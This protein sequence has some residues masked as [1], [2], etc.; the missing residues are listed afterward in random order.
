MLCLD[1]QARLLLLRFQDPFD[2]R[3]FWEVPGGGIESGETPVQA[4][5]REL[6]EEAGLPPTSITDRPVMLWRSFR[7]N[8]HDHHQP[9][10]FFLAHV[11]AAEVNFDHIPADEARILKGHRWLTRAE[12][13][14]SVDLIVPENA[15]EV[16]A[17]LGA[18]PPWAADRR[19]PREL[20]TERMVLRR[21]RPD[22]APP[23]AEIYAQP[24]FLAHM[25]ALDL[26]GTRS[27]I[28]QFVRRWKDDGFCQWAAVDLATGR[29]IGRA[30]LIRH[31]DWPLSEDPV[32]VGW[33]LH[34]D[35]WGRGLATEGGRAAIDCWRDL[36]DDDQLISITRP[37]NARSRAV[38]E[39]LGM[40]LRGAT[41][42]RDQDVVWYAIDR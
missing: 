39:R 17:R 6:F 25:S 7:F 1:E 34:R 9:E 16:A 40:T 35:Y 20:L 24:A 37:A 36:L 29:L 15:A 41:R 4:A 12:L 5:G 21:W 42:W 30:G 26:D 38:M 33:T 27:Q 10:H 28:D 22:D 14:A 18:P 13:A 3:L 31:H 11:R 23:L 32:E 2:G 8:G 19:I